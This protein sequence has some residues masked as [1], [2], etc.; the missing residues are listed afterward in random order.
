MAVFRVHPATAK[1]TLGLIAYHKGD[2]SAARHD[3][4]IGLDSLGGYY[5]DRASER[6]LAVLDWLLRRPDDRRTSDLA[7]L[8]TIAETGELSNAAK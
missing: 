1:R 3:I 8:Q 4:R 2:L 6:V 7:T 5:T